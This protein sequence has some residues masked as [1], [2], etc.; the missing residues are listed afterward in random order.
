MS[1]P[2]LI[3]FIFLYSIIIFLV[4]V[5]NFMVAM[6]IFRSRLMKKNVV[7]WYLLS[8]VIAR[9]VIGIFV[10]PARITGLFS[11]QYLQGTICKLC[12]Y[13]GQGSSAASVFSIVGISI[14]TYWQLV[15]KRD[16][17]S[18]QK[19]NILA[20]VMIW[21]AS[22]VYSIHSPITNDLV[23]QK[24]N[25]EVQWA[26]EIDPKFYTVTKYI[27]LVDCI[28]MYVIPF[29]ICIYCYIAVIIKLSA[30]VKSSKDIPDAEHK[31]ELKVYPKTVIT[32]DAL[33]KIRM[34]ITLMTLFTICSF[35]PILCKIYSSWDGPPFPYNHIIITFL[36]M[37][38]YS[39]AWY[40]IIVFAIFR[41]DLR[42]AFM[43]LFYQRGLIHAYD[44]QQVLKMTKM[45]SSSCKY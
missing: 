36:Y 34:I 16:I 22:F 38:S 7:N 43:A 18:T 44:D 35:A 10:V 17:L 13:A 24:V 28:I 4:V 23:G 26:C 45:D 42:K 12:H 32:K 37:F 9:V 27:I 39:N 30:S 40:N 3:S 15:K 25:G 2:Y 21:L 1:P 5:G 6:I 19:G 33:S 31:M 29:I 14:A 8:L 11:E 20:V 41:K